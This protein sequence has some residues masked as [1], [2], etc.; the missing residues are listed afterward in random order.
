MYTKPFS[1]LSCSQ[2]L[3][4][5]HLNFAH[6]FFNFPTVSYVMSQAKIFYDLFHP[7][8]VSCTVGALIYNCNKNELVGIF[9]YQWRPPVPSI[10][11]DASNANDLLTHLHTYTN[12]HAHGTTNTQLTVFGRQ[13]LGGGWGGGDKLSV[14]RYDIQR[15]ASSFTTSCK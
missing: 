1:A 6:T 12:T 14:R 11:C 8:K 2:D 5:F 10:H 15:Q 9:V 3:Q 13:I 4:E 7:G